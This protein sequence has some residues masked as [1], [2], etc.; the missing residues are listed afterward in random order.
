[1]NAGIVRLHVL[2]GLPVFLSFLHGSD[3]LSVRR[4]HHPDYFS[5]LAFVRSSLL[6]FNFNNVAIE[7]K[8]EG[9]AF[10]DNILIEIGM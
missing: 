9:V 7:G 2:H 5:F 10:D 1:M 6:E 8:F 4:L 3:Q